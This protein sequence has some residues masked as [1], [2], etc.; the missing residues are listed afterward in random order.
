MIQPYTPSKQAQPNV[1][2]VDDEEDV[3]TMLSGML[4]SLGYAV[5]VAHSGEEGLAALQG[6]PLPDLITLDIEMYPGMDGPEMAR[7]MAAFSVASANIPIIFV[8][9]HPRLSAIAQA[10]GTPYFLPKSDLAAF[11]SI[12][13]KANT[14][15]VAPSRLEPHDGRGLPS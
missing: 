15:R 7:Q 6:Y 5:R 9:G 14:Q 1:L 12:V 10:L 4:V 3:T 8:S 2:I 11:C 13:E